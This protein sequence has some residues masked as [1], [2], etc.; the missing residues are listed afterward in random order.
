MT[1]KQPR[2]TPSHSSAATPAGHVA[3][4]AG[5]VLTQGSVA[6]LAGNTLKQASAPRAQG[7]LFISS[8][9]V[10]HGRD[11]EHL[12]EDVHLRLSSCSAIDPDML[13]GDQAEVDML[14]LSDQ[15]VRCVTTRT[16]D[17]LFALR[18]EDEAKLAGRWLSGEKKEERISGRVSP[19]LL[20]A[21]RKKTGLTSDTDII[22]AALT[23]LALD[24][25]FGANLLA[26]TGTL[27]E[28]L[29]LAIES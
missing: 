29:E 25:D 18:T 15:M 4:I 16:G 2:T 21:V 9:L 14:I 3:K 5:N 10:C 17:P 12:D 20:E 24:D 1:S 27:P 13:T 22:T 11:T 23:R 6:K 28:D 7:S 26:K 19:S 8:F